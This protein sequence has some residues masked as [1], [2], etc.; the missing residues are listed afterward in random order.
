MIALVGNKCDETKNRQV[1]VE[2]GEAKA[3]EVCGISLVLNGVCIIHCSVC[4]SRVQCNIIFIETSAKAGYKVK[5]LFRRL[6]SP[7]I[8]HNFLTQIQH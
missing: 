5:E 4:L 6:V 3:K 7:T 2:E 8:E 1:S